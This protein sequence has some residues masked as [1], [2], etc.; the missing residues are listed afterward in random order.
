MAN[1]VTAQPADNKEQ[2]RRERRYESST[3]AVE[4]SREVHSARCTARVWASLAQRAQ[5]VGS[6]PGLQKFTKL[7]QHSQSPHAE[8]VPGC[9][10]STHSFPPGAK[11]ST[12][13]I[14][15]NLARLTRW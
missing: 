5:L 12:S 14:R 15:W 9:E 8:E 13:S 7:L 2:P 4:P 11:F 1:C 3:E 10:H 6:Q